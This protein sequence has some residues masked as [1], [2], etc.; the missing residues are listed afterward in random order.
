MRWGE[1]EIGRGEEGKK[2]G[3]QCEGRERGEKEREKKR[4]KMMEDGLLVV[5]GD[6]SR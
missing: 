2:G 4:G 5:D 6:R 1:E 3:G